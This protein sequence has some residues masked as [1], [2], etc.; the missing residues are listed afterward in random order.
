VDISL[1]HD[2]AAGRLIAWA[3]DQPA[4]YLEYR[5]RGERMALLHTIV[6]PAW[7]GYGVG[8]A[9]VKESLALARA[10]GWAVL[11]YCPFVQAYLVKHPQLQDLVPADQRAAFHLPAAAD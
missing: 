3:E 1:R 2:P 5:L 8:S 6:D 4:G 11:P 10:N 7:E 9:L